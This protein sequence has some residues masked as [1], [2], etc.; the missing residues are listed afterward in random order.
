MGVGVQAFASNDHC[1]WERPDASPAAPSFAL[2]LG[3]VLVLVLLP[4]LVAVP[5]S[6]NLLLRISHQCDRVRVARTIE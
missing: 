2:V 6:L 3:L 1:R 4:L 5:L